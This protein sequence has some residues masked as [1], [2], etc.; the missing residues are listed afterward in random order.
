MSKK[1]TQK[2]H[3]AD[4]KTFE[5]LTF[6]EQAKAINVKVVWF[7][8]ATRNHVKKCAQE[9]G[10]LRASKIPN[11]VAK[12]LRSMADQVEHL[13]TPGVPTIAVREKSTR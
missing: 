6:A 7:L 1:S 5:E 13:G 12:Q 4:T 9:H 10:V 11:K 3:K 8:S 2:R